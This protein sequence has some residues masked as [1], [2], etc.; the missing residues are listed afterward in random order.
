MAREPIGSKRAQYV[1][2]WD[3]LLERIRSEH[4]D[5]IRTREAS[6]RNWIETKSPVSGTKVGCTFAVNDQI[7]H[8]LYIDSGDDDRNAAMY[9]H[10]L[11]RKDEF[12]AAYGKKLK[13]EDLPGKHVFRIADYHAGWCSVG[14]KRRHGE[15]IDWFMDA[16]DRLRRSIAAV[17]HQALTRDGR[18]PSRGVATDRVASETHTTLESRRPP[19]HDPRWHASACE[20][21]PGGGHPGPHNLLASFGESIDL[22]YRRLGHKLG[23]TF[24]YTPTRTLAPETRLAFVP[25][26]PGVGM[27]H[28][29]IKLS[30]DEGSA[31]RTEPWG[32]GG[33][34]SNLQIQIRRLYDMLAERNEST[35]AEELMDETLA[36]N[37]CPFR[38]ADWETLVNKE[39]SIEFSQHMWARVL[40]IVKPRVIVCLGAEPAHYLDRVLRAR[41]ATLMGPEKRQTAGWGTVT[42]GVRRYTTAR[43]KLTMVRL[44]HLSRFGIFGRPE[45]HHATSE[46]ADTIS[47]ALRP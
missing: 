19:L 42:Y 28:E 9:H 18:I 44:P 12:E 38:S 30:H 24:L 16:G 45:S 2:F 15:F 33:V 8:E 43:G 37:F 5:W 35:T 13:W 29:R 1:E 46:V 11:K 6:A 4:P 21:G 17:G 31:Y 47:A 10:F 41:G 34:L 39:A 32:R 40:E 14:E 25:L 7:R 26:N 22:A 27:Y 20:V 23:W 3:K 36:L